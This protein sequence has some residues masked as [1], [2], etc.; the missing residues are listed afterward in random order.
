[1]NRLQLNAVRYPD[2]IA[3]SDGRRRWT[4]PQ[5]HADAGHIAAFLRD[6]AGVRP[7]D[8]VATCL[9]NSARHV[10]LLHAVWLCGAVVA[11]LNTR[12]A[13]PERTRQLDFLAPRLFISESES[14]YS[15]IPTLHPDALPGG[16]T[17]AASSDAS[18]AIQAHAA[19]PGGSEIPEAAEADS[20]LCSILFTSGTAGTVK[21]VP[22][23]WDNHRASA[24]GSAANLGVRDDDNWLCVI[25][26]FHIGG[27]AIVTRSLFYGTAMT[28]Q[29]NFDAADMIAVLRH[30]RITLLSVVPTMLQRLID[31]ATDFSSE[32]LPALR[33]VLLGGAAA[34]KGLWEAARTRDLPVLGTYGLTESCSQVVTASP[35]EQ[36]RM[37]GSAGRPIAGAEL[38]ICDTSGNELP[39]SVAGEIRLRGPM[40]TQGYLRAA[41]LNATAFDHGWFRTGDIG[42]IDDDALLHVLGRSDDMMITGGENVF[43][44]EIEDVLLR[45][46]SVREAAVAGVADAEWG[47][48]IAAAVVVDG[49]TE[50]AAL[51]AWCRDRL[52]GYKVPRVWK[53]MAELP[54][55][56]SGKVMRAKVREALGREGVRA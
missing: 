23:S 47:M 28:V 2:R 17:G 56:A 38:K 24:E 32:G 21:A 44:S 27:L 46:P 13:V 10:L 37:A 20:G 52:A 11:P 50:V 43:P 54:K 34:P 42:L 36:W 29:E 51:E 31:A 18:P 25:P 12:L 5:L 3:L 45:H 48:R 39:S 49:D 55:T 53:F 41:A 9:G 6:E 8:T 14:G 16:T 35:S 40:L 7:G 4:W 19:F 33:A 30:E 15:E 22:H 26:L 1:M